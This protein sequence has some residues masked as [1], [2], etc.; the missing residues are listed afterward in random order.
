MDAANTVH[1]LVRGAIAVITLDHPPVNALSHAVRKGIRVSLERADADPAVKAIVI[2]GSEKSFCGGGDIKEFGTPLFNAEQNRIDMKLQDAVQKPMVAAIGGLALGGGLELA[3]CCHYRIA[4]RG[5]RLGLPEVKIGRLPGGGGTQRLPRLIPIAEA[6]RIMLGGDPISSERGVELGLIDEI[7]DGNL[8]EGALRYTEN[9]LAQGKGT[10]RT[11]DMMAKLDNPQAFFDEMRAELECNQRGYV[12]PFRILECIEASVYLPFDEGKAVEERC[13]DRL[14][15]SDQ[16]KALRYL[17]LEERAAARLPGLPAGASVREIRNAAVIG[18]GTVGTDVAMCFAD[19]GIPVRLIDAGREARDHGRAAIVN[20]YAAMA[21]RSQLAQ[22]EMDRRLGRISLSSDLSTVS[23]A[24]IIVEALPGEMALKLSVFKALDAAA[25]PGAVLASCS[26]GLDIMQIAA[27]TARPQDVIGTHFP[28]PAHVTRLLEVI[29]GERTAAEV[30]ATVMALGTRLS[31][32]PVLSGVCGGRMGDGI[33]R[34]YYGQAAALLQEGVSARQIDRALEDWG[35]AIGPCA[36]PGIA[37]NSQSESEAER[38]VEVGNNVGS[39]RRWISDEEIVER[40]VFGLVN[41]GAR[42]IERGIARRAS[43]FDVLCTSGYGFPR[44]R[45]G[46]MFHADYVGLAQ[47][48]AAI[49]R[50][51]SGYCGELWTPAPLLVRLA[52]EGKKFVSA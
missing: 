39:A 32:V 1:Y 42:M 47:V 19:A 11:R 15:G 8:L 23:D 41:E 43:D 18:A 6:A 37:G 48:L 21:S 4:L 36:E 38:L 20:R 13:S 10:R 49:E 12:A 35:F 14:R 27:A 44:Y 7:V 26:C 2:I 5:A 9:L 24:D 40:C 51:A 33:L 17:F 16:D 22:P 34:H 29:R 3:L 45:G 31:K 50:Y 28:A 46:P 25:K 30:V 52:T